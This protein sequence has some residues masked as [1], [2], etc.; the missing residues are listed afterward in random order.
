MPHGHT[1]QVTVNSRPRI[2]RPRGYSLIEGKKLLGKGQENCFV[3]K[4]LT[5]VLDRGWNLLA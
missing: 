2:Q 4:S 1:D 3:I 5:L